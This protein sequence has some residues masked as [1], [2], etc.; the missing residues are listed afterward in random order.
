MNACATV[1]PM[2]ITQVQLAA[3]LEVFEQ[4]FATRGELGASVS[5]WQHGN[6]LLTQSAGWCEREKLRP[7]TD[8]T[9][10]PFWSATK[11]IAATCVLH[12]L[13]TAGINLDDKV[14]ELW[15]AFATA[16]KQDIT[17]AQLLSHQAGLAALDHPADIFDYP[18][19][20]RA[21]EQQEPNWQPGT[22]HGYH[23]RTFGFLLDAVVR[24][25][26]DAESLGTYWRKHF[27]EPLGLDLWIGLPE[28]EDHRVA[29]L[30]SGKMQDTPG[31]EDFYR[32]F[33]DQKSL[34][35]RAFASP[36][37]LAAIT[38]MNDQRAQRAGLPAMGGIG[39]AAS[40]GKFYAMIA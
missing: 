30:Y 27:A 2:T 12:A 14:A 11:G 22:A 13:E 26:S 24:R 20:I 23:P 39:T 31:E 36:G 35:R 5:I 6:Q 3:V 33:T 16:S 32:A 9:V 8:D 1:I 38:G 25:A 4:N 40:L 37:G 10:V 7:W 29:K 21:L 28:S 15:P 34:A 18:S 17:F 19:V